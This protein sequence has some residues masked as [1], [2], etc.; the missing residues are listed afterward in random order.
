MISPNKLKHRDNE[1]LARTGVTK[2]G[3]L[4]KR[5][6]LSALSSQSR[7][8]STFLILNDHALS[9]CS[10]KNSFTRSDGNLLLTTSTRVY[11]QQGDEAVIRIETGFE[12]LFLKGRDVA[13]TKDW[14][15]AI[16]KAINRLPE[17]SRG[18]FAVKKNG[19]VVTNRFLMLHR[20]V[21]LVAVTLCG[22]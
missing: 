6:P 4:L 2:A 20:C 3:Y 22:F 5:Q 12:V 10:E 11:N 1:L 17:L 9:Y 8:E 16:N 13:D 15:K 21:R 14:M 18:M 19:K 7:W